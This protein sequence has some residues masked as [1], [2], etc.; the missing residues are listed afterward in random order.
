MEGEVRKQ[1]I[2]ENENEYY[3][4]LVNSAGHVMCYIPAEILIL[5]HGGNDCYVD[6]FSADR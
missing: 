2:Q 3:P 1:Q 4:I 6:F 5:K